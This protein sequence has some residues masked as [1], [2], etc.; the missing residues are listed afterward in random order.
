[1]WYNLAQMNSQ[2]QWGFTIIE[3]ILFLGITG[4][5]FAGLMVG[6][7]TSIN[8]QRYKESAMS[9]KTLI[10]AQY[11]HVE[12]PR[13]S[14]DSNWNCDAV[15]GVTPDVAVGTPRGTS[16]CVLLGRYI[17]V[18]D[19]GSKIETGD[20]IGVDP[21]ASTAGITSDLDI[22]QAYVPRKSPINVELEDVG[23]QSRVETIDDSS[24]N[25]SFLILRSPLSGI[26]RTFGSTTALPDQL[27]SVVTPSA[28]SSTIKNC[29][30]PAG[31]ISIPT[32]S[33]MVNASVGSANGVVLN[34]DDS[35]C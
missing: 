13:N 23:W 6:V 20:V 27:I 1:M 22:L 7:N 2:K 16:Q 34:G 4:M 3:L 10:E 33:V 30:I 31:F 11:S 21:G 29:I 18:K 17:E 35:E 5:L 25:A 28:A 24:S 14:R 19:N 8:T 32:S 12:H 9:Y 26:I 15:Q